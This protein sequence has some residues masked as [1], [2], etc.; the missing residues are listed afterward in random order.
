MMVIGKHKV[1]NHMSMEYTFTGI[2]ILSGSLI[3]VDWN[4]SID[5][6]AVEKKGRSK[7]DAE[8]NA[9]IAYQKL[10]FWLETNLPG[11]VAVDV[12]DEDDLYIA[13][14]SSNI[15]LYCP[16]EPYDDVI[17][18][19]LHSKL[20][21]LAGAHLLIGE[22]R[23]KGSDM[24]VQYSFE[25][26]ETGYNLPSTTTEYYTEGKARDAEPWWIRDDGFSFEFI[27]PAETELS[28]EELF[29]DIVDPLDEFNKVVTEMDVSIGVKEPARIV[30]VEKWKPKKV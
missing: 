4:V 29:K 19:L 27:R 22:V 5:M 30:Q 25:P 20:S 15:M 14:L 26:S 17:V 6:V 21:T 2:R 10:F 1:K 8:Y 13:N 3:P 9:V 28:D 23:L 12:S 18:Q 11:I 24:S 7:D 16:T